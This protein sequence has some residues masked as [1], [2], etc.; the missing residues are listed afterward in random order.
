MVFYTFLGEKMTISREILEGKTSKL[1]NNLIIM[2]KPISPCLGFVTGLPLCQHGQIVGPYV[3]VVSVRDNSH[4]A[5]TA[6]V[7]LINLKE[8]GEGI[9]HIHSQVLWVHHVPGVMC[10]HWSH[11]VVQD[12]SLKPI[13]AGQVRFKITN[14]LQHT[15]G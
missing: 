9:M 11:K 6:K 2:M 5:M 10:E 3:I 14:M 1:K 8:I 7:G 12:K 4:K 15:H 13:T